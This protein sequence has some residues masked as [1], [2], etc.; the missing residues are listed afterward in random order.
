MQSWTGACLL[1]YLVIELVLK[2]IPG[3][4]LIAHTFIDLCQSRQD[5]A[6]LGCKASHP[7]QASA[8]TSTH[9]Q[10]A[11]A[12]GHQE[13]CQLTLCTGGPFEGRPS[14]QKGEGY[15]SGMA[16]GCQDACHLSAIHGTLQGSVLH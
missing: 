9:E 12:K 14:Q 3:M 4:P 11:E 2:P 5:K 1:I 7:A 15:G 16:P 8:F 6:S 10:A 13:A